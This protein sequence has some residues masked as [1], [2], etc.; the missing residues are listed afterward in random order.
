M[1]VYNTSLIK[2]GILF[3]LFLLSP[4]ILAAENLNFKY[5]RADASS[6]DPRLSKLA[7]ACHTLTDPLNINVQFGGMLT[8]HVR[9]KMRVYGSNA[10]KGYAVYTLPGSPGKSASGSVNRAALK[11]STTDPD[12]LV[13]FGLSVRG[14]AN[15]QVAQPV[16]R[17]ILVTEYDDPF[18]FSKGAYR[19]KY[20]FPASDGAPPIYDLPPYT[21]WLGDR[22]FEKY[23]MGFSKH[24]PSNKEDTYWPHYG[25]DIP[26]PVANGIEKGGW[27]GYLGK[28]IFYRG[29][30][31]V[32]S[33]KT[34]TTEKW[35]NFSQTADEAFTALSTEYD[36]PIYKD[37]MSFSGLQSGN[38]NLQLFNRDV[39][40]LELEISLVL[41]GYQPSVNIFTW[42]RDNSYLNNVLAYQGVTTHQLPLEPAGDIENDPYQTFYKNISQSY[43]RGT[44]VDD[45]S[46]N[47]KYKDQINN[48]MPLSLPAKRPGDINLVN[49]DSLTFK[50]KMTSGIYGGNDQVTVY[51]QPL[52]FGPLYT[53]SKMALSAMQVRD[54]CY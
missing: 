16:I 47:Q 1:K 37:G 8:N 9:V 31:Q 44:L 23:C 48:I 4:E 7:K 41:P 52:K 42:K 18:C 40:R 39:T 38:F 14:Q 24:T 5:T 46:L 19:D 33:G 26:G 17:P 45:S 11:S 15:L 35:V 34:E 25:E 36:F 54:A 28:Y 6:L 30:K 13:P 43:F 50:I 20:K 10:S 2:K 27:D 51:G 32:D 22:D 53:G 3:S 29:K 49:T 21:N 12:L